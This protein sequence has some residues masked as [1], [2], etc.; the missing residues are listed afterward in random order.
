MAGDVTP[1]LN[2]VPSRNQSAPNFMAMLA[3]TLQPEADLIALLNQIPGLYDLDV[4]VGQQLDVIGQWVGVSRQLTGP[5]T[6]VYFGFDDATVGFDQGV[7]Q[8]PYDPTTGIVSLPDDYF[9]VLIAVRVLNNHWDGSIP[10]AYAIANSAFAS[11]GFNILIVDNND[12][13]MDLGVVGATMITALSKQL[14]LS[15]KFDIK[16]VGVHIKNYFYSSAAGPLFGFDI[17]ST[18]VAGFDVGNWATIVPN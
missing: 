4:A 13:S 16:P 8:G 10:D 6:G 9:R 3:A 15:G 11:L 14:L 18:S 2:L 1:Y 17:S 12:L 7:W 5:L